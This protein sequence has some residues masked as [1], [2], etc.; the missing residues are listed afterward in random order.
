MVYYKI[1]NNF[2]SRTYVRELRLLCSETLQKNIFVNVERIINGNTENELRAIPRND[3]ANEVKKIIE[4]YRKLNN[5]DTKY[6]NT[7]P[8]NLNFYNDDDTFNLA[9]FCGFDKPKNSHIIPR[10]NLHRGPKPC[11]VESLLTITVFAHMDVLDPDEKS[12]IFGT[13]AN[14]DFEPIVA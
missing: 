11:T 5:T 3:V 9:K 2:M 4:Y 12:Y 10:L 7:E 13:S 14:M 6:L 8:Q 1:A